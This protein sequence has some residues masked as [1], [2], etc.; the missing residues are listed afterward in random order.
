MSE[1]PD[2][3]LPYPAPTI[4]LGLGKL[5]LALLERLG[6][7][8]ETLEQAGAGASLKNLRL[9]HLRADPSVADVRWRE[10]ERQFVEIARYTGEGD[11]PTLALDFVILR[12]LGLIRY[13]NGTYQVAVPRDQ[14]VVEVPAG[15]GRADSDEAYF[16]RRRF[17]EWKALSPDPIT[18][19]ERLRALKERYS[20]VDLFISPLVN[21]IRQ[22]HSPRAVLG[23]VSRCRALAEGRDPSPWQ[24]FA[25]AIGER[26]DL[27]QPDGKQTI[28]FERDW[29]EPG[30]LSGL[31][32][33][34][35]ED[36]RAGWSEWVY[37][38]G[39]VDALPALQGHQV[40]A[41]EFSLTLP[42]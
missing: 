3:R 2:M 40:P 35:S 37:G 7:D 16:A 21:R 6:E 24:W 28:L 36:P 5:R 42:A 12:S 1:Q 11:L 10:S 18:S 25:R 8:W 38:L 23:C 41:R 27:A 4:V 31:L 33:G 17:F 39:A 30:D 14:G 9:I 32:D 34:I 13:R 20:E 22:G 29:L 19:V 26:E 15:V